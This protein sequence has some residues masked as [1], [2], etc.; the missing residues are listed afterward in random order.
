MSVLALDLNTVRCGYAFGGEADGAPRTGSWPFFGIQSE[1]DLR[2]T[3]GALAQSITELCR[4]IR[5]TYAY[6]EAPIQNPAWGSTN[7]NAM[8]GT[9][10]VV[11]VA[12]AMCSNAGAI[13]KPAHI[14]SW[15]KTFLGH[16]YPDD[17]KAATMARCKLLGWPIKN[18]DEADAAG[19]W[20][21]GMSN[22]YPR[23][24]PK[25]TPL[26]AGGKP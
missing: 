20:C 10:S 25:G 23:W 13:T 17:P 24:A 22:N 14:N 2:R 5:P 4:L 3:L 18:D 19:I 16:A 7:A 12:M 9:Y 21:W 11:A 6:Y 26:F 15:R 8:R 1:D